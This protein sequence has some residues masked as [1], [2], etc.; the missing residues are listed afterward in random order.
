LKVLSGSAGLPG[1][2]ILLSRHRGHG[3]E[4]HARSADSCNRHPYHPLSILSAD[5][6]AP[7]ESLRALSFHRRICYTIPNIQGYCGRHGAVSKGMKNLSMKNHQNLNI[8]DLFQTNMS[9]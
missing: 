2:R 7:V 9:K 8:M 5:C 3:R 6:C 4:R 1:L